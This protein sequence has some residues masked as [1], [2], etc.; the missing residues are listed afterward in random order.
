LA[1]RKQSRQGEGGDNAAA[2]AAQTDSVQE[3]AIDP[4]R[5]D[6]SAPGGAA[7]RPRKKRGNPAWTEGHPKWGGRAKGTPNRFTHTIQGA[8]LE[9]F[10]KLGGADWLVEKFG[11][12]KVGANRRALLA[13]F[14]KMIPLQMVGLGEVSPDE[15]ARRVRER[16]KLI[17]D[18]TQ[19]KPE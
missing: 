7:A 3:A 14:G 5:A 17:A 12:S 2:P 10:I 6:R 11:K 13:M 4:G 9:A 16:M 1:K 19:P 15:T 18:T 8:F